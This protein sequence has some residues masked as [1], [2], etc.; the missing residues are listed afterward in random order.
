MKR[1]LISGNLY[2]TVPE[3]GKAG[4]SFRYPTELYNREKI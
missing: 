1:R 3:I 4:K 2:N